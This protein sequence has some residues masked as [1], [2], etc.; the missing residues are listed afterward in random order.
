[1]SASSA[2]APVPTVTVYWRP[3]CP[4]C[5]VLRRG[6]RRAGLPTND[7]DIWTEPEGAAFVRAHADGNETVPTVDIGGTVLVNPSA[8]RV[9]ALAADIGITTAASPGRWWRRR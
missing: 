3:G 2:S 9:V 1:V 4:F 5:L 6:L 8:H 7:I